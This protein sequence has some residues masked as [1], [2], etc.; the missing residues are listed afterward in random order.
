MAVLAADNFNRANNASLGANWTIRQ[1]DGWKILSNQAV[2]TTLPTPDTCEFYSA[3][4]WPSDHYSQAA[5]FSIA[6]TSDQ[7]GIGVTCRTETLFNSFDTY[8]CVVNAAVSNNVSVHKWVAGNYT[9]IGQRTQAWTDGDVLRMEM[10]GT[11]IRV[12]RNGVQMGADF[13]DSDI[14]IG[15]AGLSKIAAITNGI[16]DDWEGG[17]LVSPGPGDDPP[18]GFLGRGAGW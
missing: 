3:I 10:Q 5:L 7:T 14:L 4:T 15:A 8:G 12:Y 9:L 6:G 17:T 16:T 13:T 1:N 18:I 2:P 11:T